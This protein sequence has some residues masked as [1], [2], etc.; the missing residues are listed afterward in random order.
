MKKK[1]KNNV[2]T[3]TLPHCIFLHDVRRH[4][5]IEM[6]EQ[7]CTRSKHLPQTLRSRQNVRESRAGEP[8]SGDTSPLTISTSEVAKQPLALMTGNDVQL[9]RQQKKKKKKKNTH[10]KKKPQKPS[11][12]TII[13]LN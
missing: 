13:Q 11:R 3:S 6:H 2:N 4:K 10:T 12:R 8:V 9:V 5:R 1:R 7:S